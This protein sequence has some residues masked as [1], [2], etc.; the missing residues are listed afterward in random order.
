LNRSVWVVAALASVTFLPAFQK[1]TADRVNKT[2]GG[3]ALKA[4]D[5]VAYFQEGKA[6]KGSGEF[7]HEW[8]GA[9]WQF[10]SETNRDLFAENPE[11]FAPQYGG[12]CAYG[13]SR[14]YFADIDPHVFKV[15]D[16][17][18]YLNYNAEV[19]RTWAKDIPGFIAKAESNWPQLHKK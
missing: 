15:V 4:Y 11:R 10:T 1:T 9:R 2:S 3:I 5:A 6:R 13:V 19:G 8:M 17:K 7:E 18:L 16:G 12:Y 14:G